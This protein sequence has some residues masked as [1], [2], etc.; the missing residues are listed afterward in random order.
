MFSLLLLRAASGLRQ[1][2]P[3]AQPDSTLK[4]KVK[5]KD[6]QLMDVPG[7]EDTKEIEDKRVQISFL[8]AQNMRSKG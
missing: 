6:G 5:L 7:G 2:H 4:G 8:E 1:S 3:I